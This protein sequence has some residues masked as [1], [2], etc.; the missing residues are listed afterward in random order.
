MWDPTFLFRR[1]SKYDGWLAIAFILLAF[2]ILGK[3]SNRALVAQLISIG[4]AISALGLK[5]QKHLSILVLSLN[6][7]FLVS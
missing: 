7:W 1:N 3:S 6:L 5:G 2:C 4:F